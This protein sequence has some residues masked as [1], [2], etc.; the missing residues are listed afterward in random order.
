MTDSD[1]PLRRSVLHIL[2]ALSPAP[3]HGLGIADEVERITDGTIQLGPGTLYRSLKEM[4][5]RSL[6][7]EVPGPDDADPRRRYYELT[8]RGRALLAAEVGRLD[9]LVRTAR[10]RDVV[11]ETT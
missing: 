1:L 3:R 6:I 2:L 10:E 7:E 11:P 9:S 5:E 4:S 8:G